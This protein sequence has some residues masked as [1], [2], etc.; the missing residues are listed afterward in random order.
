MKFTDFG[1]QIAIVILA[2]GLVSGCS[3]ADKATSAAKSAVSA[4]TGGSASPAAASAIS[5][6][7]SAISTAKANNWIWRD[8]EKF[9]KQAEEAAKGG[10]EAKSIKLASKAKDQAEMA[11]QQFKMEQGM[12]R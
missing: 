2:A 4:V 6:A 10:D 5:D 7:K 9:L 1:K 11:V 12:N 3:T 8:T